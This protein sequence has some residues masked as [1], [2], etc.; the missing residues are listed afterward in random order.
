MGQ[1]GF[2]S[3]TPEKNHGCIHRDQK[4]YKYRKKIKGVFP[5]GSAI[6]SPSCKFVH[7]FFLF[8]SHR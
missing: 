2:F 8:C 5:L 6:N 3:G 4:A 1:E 7:I